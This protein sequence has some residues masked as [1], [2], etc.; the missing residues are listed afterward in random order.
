[1]TS[2]SSRIIWLTCL[3]PLSIRTMVL[4]ISSPVTTAVYLLPLRALNIGASISPLKVVAPDLPSISV[5]VEP[6]H[7]ATP[8]SVALKP[9]FCPI[10]YDQ[11]TL[12]LDEMDETVLPS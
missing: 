5:S 10:M 11:F 8:L 7:T 12:P 2:T 3:P 6:A 1:M 4:F 9:A